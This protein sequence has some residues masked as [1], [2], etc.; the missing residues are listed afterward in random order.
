MDVYDIP[1]LHID[2]N[3][4]WK[5]S[6]TSFEKKKLQRIFIFLLSYHGFYLAIFLL[7]H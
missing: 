3:L 7:T 5:F 2:V 1:I 6:F 4:F